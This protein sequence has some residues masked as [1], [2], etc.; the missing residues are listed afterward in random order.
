MRTV[1]AILNAN[2]A[3][4]THRQFPV[5]QVEAFAFEQAMDNDAD[6]F[7]IDIGDHD[8]RLRYLLGRDTE[9]KVGIFLRDEKRVA[10]QLFVGFSDVIA[11][12]SDDMILSTTGRDLSS[13]ALTDAAPGRMPAFMPKPYIEKRARQLG[14][15]RTRIH[16]M[17]QIGTFVSDG[18]ETEWSMWY[19]M[20][21]HAGFFMWTEADGTLIVDNLNY[22]PSSAQYQIGTPPRGQSANG[23]MKPLMVRET[24]NTQGRLGD[25]W[26]YGQNAKTASVFAAHKLDKSITSWQRKPRKIMS[27]STAK[28][29][30]QALK[31]ADLELFESIV[32]AY[33][34]EVT[35]HD[36]L[37]IVKQNT[38]AY[39]RIPELA[40]EGRFFI[41]GA[42]T[43]GSLDGGIVQVIRM[44]QRQYALTKRVSDDPKIV[45]PNEARN[46]TT[47]SVGAALSNIGRSLGVRWADSFVRAAREFG[48][49]NGWDLGVFLGVLLSICQ[50]ESGF[51]NVRQ[52][53]GT[54]WMTRE[55][56]VAA[57]QGDRNPQ[58]GTSS[59]LR[60]YELEFAN[61]GRNTDNS[62]HPYEA[63]VGPMQL[64]STDYKDWAD[65][66]GWS[67]RPDH[68][69]LTGGRWN[70]DSNIRAAARALIVKLKAAPAANPNEPDS[71]WLGVQRY[72]GSGPSAVAY[73][74]RVKSI[75]TQ[76]FSALAKTAVSTS[77]KIAP[78]TNVTVEVPGHGSLHLVPQT[79]TIVRKAINFAIRHL[80]DR[81]Q[82]GG[83][84]PYYD[85]SSFVTA[86]YAYADQTMR[87]ILDEPRSGSHGENTYTLY[88]KG[89]F[90]SVNRDNLLAGDLVFFHHDGGST[91]EHVGMYLSE[92][93]FI[94]DPHTG[95][96][97]KVSALGES[98][99]S[100]HYMGARRL[101]QWFDPGSM[102]AG[103]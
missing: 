23:W 85:C 47:A 102:E 46:I 67:G 100:E 98:W 41:V 92:G 59:V 31:E 14:F 12:S 70:P 5:Q 40:L 9:V 53:H 32:G 20:V 61:A 96:V 30:S 38:M 66:Y 16:K 8:N 95:D 89:R 81:Y 52:D 15:P 22:S 17:S 10:R 48:Q 43:Q 65:E 62:Y 28:S 11:K 64:T 7:S 56:Y 24:K 50:D 39:V 44:R 21:R 86:A 94:H 82:W 99:Y 90:P 103:D 87:D 19:R 18:S 91:P 93:M 36:P 72:N 29:N 55:A 35:I 25:V 69:E 71:I 1:L 78:G 37:H 74:N 83:F 79:P 76:Q 84:G 6:A 13:L 80:G 27:S 60:A 4:E 101:I 45:N 34:I 63:G 33:E 54:E 58:M 51:R 26:V 77:T 2:Q 57:H 42:R 3:R 75:Y 88:R 68:Q 49:A 97:V 73:A